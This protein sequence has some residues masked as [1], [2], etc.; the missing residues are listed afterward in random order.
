MTALRHRLGKLEA[1]HRADVQQ[2]HDAG[3][4]ALGRTMDRKH[5]QLIQ[6]WMQENLG[7]LHARIALPHESVYETLKRLQPPALVR[8]VWLLTDAH[9]RTGCQVSLAPA[10]AELYLAD[11]NV[12]PA[13]PCDGC[14]YPLPIRGALQPDHTFID[15][16]YYL[17]LCPVCGLDNH[18]QEDDTP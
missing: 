4:R 5:V 15:V 8:A 16:G 12:Y 2:R 13:S 11:E 9:V 10:V 18:L 6:D 1:V 14:G 7:G 17:G 3:T